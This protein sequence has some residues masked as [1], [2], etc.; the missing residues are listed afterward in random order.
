MKGEKIIEG[1]S[2]EEGVNVGVWL[3]KPQAR[4]DLGPGFR[5]A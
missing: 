1:V 5:R 3:L 4:V 2:G